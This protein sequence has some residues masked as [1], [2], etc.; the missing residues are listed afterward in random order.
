MEITGIVTRNHPGSAGKSCMP[1]TTWQRVCGERESLLKAGYWAHL[2]KTGSQSGAEVCY[3]YRARWAWW[4]CRGP[5]SLTGKQHMA[6]LWWNMAETLVAGAA[7]R[8]AN[9]HFGP[10]PPPCHSHTTNSFGY[11]GRSPHTLDKSSIH[12][13]ELHHKLLAI[14]TEH[15]PVTISRPVGDKNKNTLSEMHFLAGC[16]AGVVHQC[17]PGTSFFCAV[18][19]TPCFN[20]TTATLP[21]NRKSSSGLLSSLQHGWGAYLRVKLPY[22]T[23]L[24]NGIL[25]SAA[26]IRGQAYE[27]RWYTALTTFYIFEMSLSFSS[28]KK[29]T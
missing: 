21:L 4:H 8:Q 10:N 5:S 22:V 26:A 1:R 16:D 17:L 13:C 6:D 29:I 18:T 3:N 11:Q 7:Q 19:F 20:S 9:R 15:W 12:R 28:F 14:R 2:D 24:D 27:L 25:Q 23:S